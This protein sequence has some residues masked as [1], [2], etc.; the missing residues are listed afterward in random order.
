MRVSNHS[1]ALVPLESWSYNSPEIRREGNS[2]DIGLMAEA[3]IYYGQVL[4][5]IAT[6]PQ[7]A[8][9]INWFVTKNKY[10]DLIS[11]FNDEII[12]LY[13]YGFITMALEP[14]LF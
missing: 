1:R 8:E 11:L 5:N 3:L 13:H 6:Q 7:L 4:V 10:S 12:K 2:I 14:Q 9:L